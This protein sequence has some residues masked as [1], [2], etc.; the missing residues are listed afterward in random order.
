MKIS[1]LINLNS[2]SHMACNEKSE[3]NFDFVHVSGK[4]GVTR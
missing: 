2:S 4:V 1:A 3:F